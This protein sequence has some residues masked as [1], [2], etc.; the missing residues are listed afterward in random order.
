MVFQVNQKI[1]AQTIVNIRRTPGHVGKP[2]DDVIAALAYGAAA[3]VSGLAEIVDGL[4]W[5]PVRLPRWP[6]HRRLG[7]GGGRRHP[8]GG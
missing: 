1:F 4:T 8:V 2:S 3:I 6:D 5:W 7:G